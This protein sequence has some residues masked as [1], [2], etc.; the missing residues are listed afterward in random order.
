MTPHFVELH[1]NS[2]IGLRAQ[3][4]AAVDDARRRM[5]NVLIIGLD[6]LASLDDEAMAATIV[7]LRRYRDGGGSVRLLT[8]NAAHRERLALAGL[9]RIFDVVASAGDVHSSSALA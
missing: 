3:A 2:P 8:Q 5:A 4:T 6:R 7:A 1:A 9:D